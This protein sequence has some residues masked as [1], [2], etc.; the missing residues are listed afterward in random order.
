MT[1]EEVMLNTSDMAWQEAEG[2]PPGTGIKVLRKGSRTHGLTILLKLPA[3]WSFG[4]HCHTAVEQHYV[5]EGEYESQ[6]Q[7]FPQGS[8]QLILKDTNHGPFT[9]KSGAIVLV[10]WDPE[11]A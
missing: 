3:N 6:G 2:Y 10:M 4:K 11:E 5:L 9:T 8:Y 7:V 1:T